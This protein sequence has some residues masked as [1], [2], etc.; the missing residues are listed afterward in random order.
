LVGRPELKSIKFLYD[1]G[2][3]LLSQAVI[4]D[5]R[6]EPVRVREFTY[7]FS[8]HEG[9]LNAI[10]NRDVEDEEFVAIWPAYRYADERVTVFTLDPKEQKV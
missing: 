8:V 5:E 6:D 3:E 10:S 1:E 7:V 2:F 9:L 4:D